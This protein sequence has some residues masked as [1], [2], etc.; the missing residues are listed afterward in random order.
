[1]KNYILKGL[2]CS[3]AVFAMTGLAA[4]AQAQQFGWNDGN[5][6]AAPSDLVHSSCWNEA[7]E[8]YGQP[9]V[10]AWDWYDGASTNVDMTWSGTNCSGNVNVK[11]DNNLTGGGATIGLAW[12]SRYN[13]GG[14][15]I[16]G[17]VTVVSSATNMRA[18]WCHEVGHTLGLGHVT[19]NSSCMN[20]GVGSTT[21]A[22]LSAAQ[23]TQVNNQVQ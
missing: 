13:G 5:S 14:L 17:A 9:M 19:N 20:A 3:S 15:C 2:L 21:P 18:L 12:C 16:D 8:D 1:M 22:T 10:D 7:S 11:M 23:T 4:L 6:G